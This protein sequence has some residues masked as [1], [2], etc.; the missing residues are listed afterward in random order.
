MKAIVLRH[1]N[2]LD[3]L[4]Y[5]DVPRPIPAPDEI[6]V[7]IRAVSLNYRDL[8]ILDGAYRKQQKHENLIPTSDAA[9]EVVEIGNDVTKYQTGDRV[10]PLFFRDWISGEPDQKTIKSDWG[11]D[12]DGMLCEYKVFKAH[13]LVKTPPHLSDEEAACLPCAGL[14][15]WNAIIGEGQTKPDDLV[16][17]QGTGGVSLF[18]LQFAKVMGARVI[19]T[20]SSDDK[21]AKTVSLDATHTI[22][23]LRQPEW[24]HAALEISNGSGIDHLVELGGTETL[25]QSLIAVRPGG[26]IS[27]IGVLSGATFGDVLLPFI[28]SR[29]VRLQGVT[30]GNRDDM[31]AMC[32]LIST[33]KINPVVSEVFAKKD[34]RFAFERLKSG[35]HF[36]KICISVA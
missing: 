7:Q 35:Q 15:A 5:I 30:V 6:L 3:A 32:E 17:T 26:T 21:L 28:V 18:A 13:Q 19:I 12:R 34:S 24:G 29:K 10:I 36:G 23:Y 4:E 14:T 25:K 2:G 33:H 27:M 31:L 1:P 22:N 16:L 20:S 11:R 8:V 9:G